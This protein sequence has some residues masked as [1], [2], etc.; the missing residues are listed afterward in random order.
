SEGSYDGKEPVKLMVEHGED[1]AIDGFAVTDHDGVEES[2][3]ACEIAEDH[4]TIVLPGEEVST[5]D[6]H[7]LAIGVEERIQPRNPFQETVEKIREKGGAAVVPHPFQKT[8]HGVSK[9][10]IEEVDAVEAY[11]AW[12]FTGFQNH[13]ARKFADHR[14]F[15]KV[16][17]S[18]AH[19]IGLIGRAYTKIHIDKPKNE[20]EPDDII[21]ALRDGDVEMEGSRAPM[22][23][24]AYHY[25]KATI[26]KT[27]YVVSEVLEEL[28]PELKRYSKPLTLGY[29][30]IHSD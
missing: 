17:G 16:A 28:V 27:N 8:R 25:V 20:I 2:L 10:K 23:R 22:H 21:E 30:K 26:R 5:S 13:R 29:R 11:N 6:G 7:L 19:S 9:R 18:D 15:P 1:I 14:G 12:L 3:K 4:D 24:A